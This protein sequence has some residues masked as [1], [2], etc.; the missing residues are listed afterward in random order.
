MAR[1]GS[2]KY[3]A[4]KFGATT[5]TRLL[6]WALEV[7]WDGDGAFDGSSEGG[8]LRKVSMSRGR[9][10]L[11]KADGGG[12][13]AVTPGEVTLELLNTSRRFDAAYTGSPLYPHV[14]PG[15]KLRLS[16]RDEATGTVYARFVGKISDIRPAH[17]P[18]TVTITAV[19][20]LARL[21]KATASVTTQ[22]DIRVDDAIDLVLDAAGWTDGRDISQISDKIPIWST[23]NQKGLKEAQLLAEVALANLCIAADGDLRVVGRH[24]SQTAAV[25][26]TGADILDDISMNQPWDLIRNVIKITSGG[27]STGATTEIFRLKDVPVLP[28]GGSITF[29]AKFTDSNGVACSAENIID[30]VATTDIKA[31][32]RKEGT[33]TNLTSQFAVT[34]EKFSDYANVT[35]TNNSAVSGAVTLMRLR[36]DPVTVTSVTV[37]ESDAASIAIYNRSE[38]VIVNRWLQNINSARD[39]ALAL[40]AVLKSPQTCPAVKIMA[41]PALQFAPDLFDLVSLTVAS[42]DI[43]GTYVLGSID[44]EWIDEIGGVAVTTFRMEPNLAPGGY[45]TFPAQ[46]GVDTV[47]GY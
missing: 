7:D 21:S 24:R 26:L 19:D 23:S 43:S 8:Y 18:E 32:T 1:F 37:E 44:E 14:V 6:S 31:Y 30:P 46:L 13:Q 34:V 33:G 17:N 25:S 39:F 10:S 12:F 27:V 20:E 35:I 28:A 29:E 3:G 5:V 16:V 38:L 4:E 36:G 11:L 40:L 2:F 22:S 15:R 9:K 45:W 47:L 41:S 42:R